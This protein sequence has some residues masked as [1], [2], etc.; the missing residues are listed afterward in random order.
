MAYHTTVPATQSSPITPALARLVIRDA[1]KFPL[2]HFQNLGIDPDA[3]RHRKKKTDKRGNRGVLDPVMPP[4][5]EPAVFFHS[6]LLNLPPTL[7]HLG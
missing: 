2:L 7:D 4:A 5:S 6:R 1:G 3:S